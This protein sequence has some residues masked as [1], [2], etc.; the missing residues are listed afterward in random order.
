MF[1][2]TIIFTTRVFSFPDP[3]EA[4][5]TFALPA[6]LNLHQH[7]CGTSDHFSSPL[8]IMTLERMKVLW[9]KVKNKVVK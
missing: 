2:S 4:P 6:D 8:S 7:L 1:E 9:F 3:R 5:G